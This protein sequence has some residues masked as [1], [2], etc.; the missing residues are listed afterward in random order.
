MTQTAYQKFCATRQQAQQLRQLAVTQIL[1]DGGARRDGLQ[2]VNFA[3]NDYLGLS[4]HPALIAAAQDGAVR[5]GAGSTASRLI[6]GNLPI[7]DDIERKLAAGKGTETALVMCSGYQA[8]LA[9]LAALAD[10]DVVGKPV[11]ILADRLIHNSLLQGALLSGARLARFQHNDREHLTSLLRQHSGKNTHIIIVSE[12]VFGMDGDRADLATLS[13]LAQSHGAMLYIDEAHATGVLGKNGFGLCAD[14]SGKIDVVMG[15]FG[16]ALGSFGAYI[17]SSAT[18]RNYLIQRCGGLIYSTGLPPATLGSIN[19]ALDL[20]PVLQKERDYVAQLATTVRQRLTEQ[21]WDCGA[22]TT[23]IIPIL[24]GDEGAALNLSDLLR[25][26][27]FLVPAIRPPTVPR[28]SSRL[29]LS[30]SAAHKVEAV[31]RFLAVMVEY[32]ASFV[33]SKAQSL[34]S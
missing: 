19:A 26:K 33:T 11:M 5:F 29:R 4:H 13:D 1:P 32:A 28:D 34:A 31:E 6:T 12:S 17:A 24:L 16:K 27:G 14:H 20:L 15:T 2:L 25:Q 30:L 23:Q 22:S 9:V 10:A 3:S 18:I 8:N 7:Y 21:G